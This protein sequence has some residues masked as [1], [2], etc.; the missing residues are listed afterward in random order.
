MSLRTRLILTYVLIVLLCLG[1]AAGAVSLLLQN[2]RD[3]FVQARLND[4][5]VALYVQTVSLLEGRTSWNEVWPVKGAFRRITG[6]I[7]WALYS[8]R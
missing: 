8:A 3:R 2:Y 1:V 5:T 6:A 4:M 7:P